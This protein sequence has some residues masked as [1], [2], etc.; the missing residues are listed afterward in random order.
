VAAIFILDEQGAVKL[1][2]LLL[3]L[4]SAGQPLA[5]RNGLA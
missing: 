1:L 3:H 2:G 5:N 4:S